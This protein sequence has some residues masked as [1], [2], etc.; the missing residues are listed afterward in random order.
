VLLTLAVLAG[1]ER[2]DPLA[3]EAERQA[4]LDSTVPRDEY[5]HQVERKGVALREQRAADQRRERAVA[6]RA[7]FATEAAQLTALVADAR[8]VN[9]DVLAQIDATE[10]KRSELASR[11][12]ELERYL[13]SQGPAPVGA[14]AP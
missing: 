8:R 5:W 7:R 9:A 4:L 10:R 2:E 3:L 6:E 11:A 14:P 13:A 1:C 12:T